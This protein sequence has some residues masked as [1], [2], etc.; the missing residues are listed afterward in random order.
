M[1]ALVFSDVHG[2]SLAL[3]YLLNNTRPT[4]YLQV[5][6]YRC[7][8]D[9][10]GYYADPIEVWKE[11]LSLDPD[12]RS[13]NHDMYQRRMLLNGDMRIGK[14]E[15]EYV[16]WTG[17][18]HWELFNAAPPEI[19]YQIERHLRNT[20]LVEPRVERCDGYTLVYVHGS[21]A[22]IEDNEDYQYET[23]YLY[24]KTQHSDC[25]AIGKA[26]YAARDLALAAGAPADERVI[27]FV[28]HTHMP[29]I[30]YFDQKQVKFKDGQWTNAQ[31][32][33]PI[34][35]NDLF[36]QSPV[37]AVNGGAVGYLRA[38][39][40]LAGYTSAAHIDTKN[41]EL[42]MIAFD[43]IGRPLDR[44][45]RQMEAWT[46]RELMPQI[47]V[48]L[49][50]FYLKKADPGRSGTGVDAQQRARYVLLAMK[51]P[52]AL[53]EHWLEHI[54]PKL[55]EWLIHGTPQN[56][57]EVYVYTAEAFHLR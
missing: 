47:T 54:R 13:G 51:S 36:A 14:S 35:L 7:L 12:T 50:D 9:L 32:D 46:P 39:E 28:G 27:L 15:S 34:D 22:Y 3:K 37:I 1:R 10:F 25:E 52:E 23:W 38:S 24:P 8:G 40:A 56:E 43:M 29:M 30:A 45:S 5:D 33:A 31:V 48:G 4:A 19:H 53:Y 57:N 26:M 11:V 21:A 49:H 6:V 55:V 18:L 44:F 42:R 16:A 20:H 2:N 41:H 17:L